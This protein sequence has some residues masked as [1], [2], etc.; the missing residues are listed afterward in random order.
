[1]VADLMKARR[2]AQFEDIR[3]PIREV[4]VNPTIEEL[5]LW[6]SETL[7]NPPRWLAADTETGAGQIKCISFARSRGEAIC[8]PF[9]EHDARGRV[10]G[11]YWPSL[12]LE[13]KAWDCVERL[14]ASPI[15]KV[16]QNGLYDFQYVHSLGIRPRNC[17][18]D[19]MLLHHSIYP[20]MQKGLGFLG[21]IYTN[22]ASWKLMNRRK[23]DTEKRDE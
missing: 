6:T 18:E 10:I 13:L 4:L 11:S 14:L 1:M 23:A 19:T 17:Y 16:W 15:D 12:A 20:E 5:E 7:A 22:E 8:V 21:S 9:V 3:R 2:E